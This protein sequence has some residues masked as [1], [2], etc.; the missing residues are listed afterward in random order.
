MTEEGRDGAAGSF[1]CSPILFHHLCVSKD[2]FR[3]TPE[4]EVIRSFQIQPNCSAT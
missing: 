3:R 4:T 2:R 1:T